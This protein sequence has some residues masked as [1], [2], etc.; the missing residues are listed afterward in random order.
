MIND[1]L[2]TTLHCC[3]PVH[4]LCSDVQNVLGLLLTAALGVV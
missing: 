2:K 4:A 1:L 3:H